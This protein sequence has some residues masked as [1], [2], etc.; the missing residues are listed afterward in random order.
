MIYTS[1]ISR[2][3]F[4]KGAAVAALAP[5]ILPSTAW[6]QDAPSHRT[7]MGMIGVG[8]RGRSHLSELSF[9]KQRA[10]VLA[11]CDVNA[12][13]AAKAKA[14]AEQAF[15]TQACTVYEDFR[16]LIARD[17]LDAVCIAVPDQWHALIA[18]A[19]AKAG[20]HLYSEKPFAYSVEEGKAM[21]RA[22]AE[23][24]VVFQHGTQ[25]RSMPNFRQACEVA[26]N[27]RLG[28]VHSIRV[29]SPFGK[30]GGST[31]A[32]PVPEGLNYDFWL[33][34]APEKPYTPGR[35]N[36]AGG[37]GWYHIRD[38]SGGWVT[39]WGSHDV[40]IAQWGNGTDHTG[41][42]EIEGDGEYAGGGVYDTL[43]KWHIE[44]RYGNGV[45]LIYASEDEHSHGVKFEGDEGWVFV[46]R[47]TL[48]A[49]DKALLET[50]LGPDAVRLGT[51]ENHMGNF[52]DCIQGSQ[53]P[54]A[55]IEAAHR[56]TAICHLCNIAVAVGRPL[57][58]DPEKEEILGDVEASKLMSRTMRGP[59]RL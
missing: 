1:R 42:L 52:L 36:G 39:A 7:T 5:Q 54:A 43:W 32:A 46:N 26:R 41:P 22:V 56:S 19:A 16:E 15:G 9:H 27:G 30:Q 55:P 33:G 40:D 58:W 3:G 6:G 24:G 50:P 4:L 34:P 57:R 17:D 11:V 35:C 38:Y 48:E 2:R 47:G 49:S 21:V 10:Q 45:K 12:T 51:S 53:T 31:E 13:N 25:Q 59:W 14:M 23:A 20:K 28:A 29:G 8:D 37:E 18:V 44:C